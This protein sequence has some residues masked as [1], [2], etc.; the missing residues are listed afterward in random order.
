MQGV[1]WP[2]W[3]VDCHG[4]GCAAQPPVMVA[5]MHVGRYDVPWVIGDWYIARRPKYDRSLMKVNHSRPSMMATNLMSR[6]WLALLAC[7]ALA[8]MRTGA[9]ELEARAYA[10]NPVGARFALASLAHSQGDMLLNS[11]SP[12]ENFEIEADLVF[13]GL[14]GTFAIADRVASLSLVVP[15]VDGTATGLLNGVPERVDR[16][17]IGDPRVRFSMSLLPDSAQ[18]AA[19]FSRAPPDRTLG[20]SLVVVLPTGEYFDE[21][22]IN[23]GSNR[24]AFKPEIGGSRRFGRW[25]LDGAVGV[26]LFADNDEYLGNHERSQEPLVAAQAHLS[27]TFAPRLWLGASAT[28]YTG[29]TTSVDDVS[30]RNRQSNSRTGLT[31][32]LPVS[33]RHSIRLAWSTGVTARFGGD[34]DS[35]ALTWQYLWFD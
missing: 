26:W 12:I 31:L 5:W 14:G 27:Y 29:G 10:P 6:G 20:A 17:G 30:D 2:E 23:I 24:W 1:V 21:K 7:L 13:A 15:F 8:P 4:L 33:S 18:D 11:S 34:L 28:W 35:Y 16:R 9:Q 19:S 25:N 3:G 32:A 22:L